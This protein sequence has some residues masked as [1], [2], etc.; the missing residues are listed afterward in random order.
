MFSHE[1]D[2]IISKSSSSATRKRSRIEESDSD[3]DSCAEKIVDTDA[4]PSKTMKPNDSESADKTKGTS[5][6][7]TP[8]RRRTAR[9][10]TGK[11]VDA[12]APLSKVSPEVPSS[13]GKV[14]TSVRFLVKEISI[15]LCYRMGQIAIKRE[16]K[17]LSHQEKRLPWIPHYP[18][19]KL[20]V[21]RST[22]PQSLPMAPCGMLVGRMERS[23]C[24]L[25]FPC[26]LN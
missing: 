24:H 22:I 7:N 21:F 6:L 15:A 8:P 1:D 2:P 26:H 23:E 12:T 13:D 4:L 5:T 16:R 3:G 18:Q 14:S 9:K 19:E 17:L 11:V 10:H 25:L 20:S